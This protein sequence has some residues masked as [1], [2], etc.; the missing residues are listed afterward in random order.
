MGNN[1]SNVSV[2]KPK[3]GG[4]VWRAPI[5]TTLP[6]TA[7]EALNEAFTCMGFV[8]SDGMTNSNGRASTDISAW[9]GTVVASPQTSYADKFKATFIE[10]LNTEVLK[11]S[12]G[13]S[14][15]TG[16]LAT[17]LHIKANAQEDTEHSYVIDYELN[18]NIKQRTVIPCGKI[19]EVGDVVYKDDNVIGY[20]LT[21][22]ALPDGNEDTHHTY[23]TGPVTVTL[24]TSSVTVVTGSTETLVATT[25]PV[26]GSVTWRSSNTAV[27]TVSTAGLVTGVDE[28]VCTVIAT[29]EGAVAHCDVTVITE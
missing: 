6:T 25:V 11:A 14:N 23:Y 26:G 18:G 17:G 15:V 7:T 2:G 1:K 20:P 29:Y 22:S 28:G 27:A 5:G 3:I 21:I 8:S 10:A 13:D 12:Y 24:N 4:A 16:A 9:G 19:T